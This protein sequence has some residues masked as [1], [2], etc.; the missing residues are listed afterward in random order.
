MQKY[1]QRANWQVC[2]DDSTRTNLVDD[3]FEFYL[4]M[5]CV[6]M[7]KVFN[8]INI[9]MSLWRLLLTLGVQ[10]KCCK[11]TESLQTYCR[12]SPDMVVLI[13]TFAFCLHFFKGWGEVGYLSICSFGRFDTWC[14]LRGWR[15]EALS[16][17]TTSC[18]TS[19]S[20]SPRSQR[21]LCH[22]TFSR[23][24][25]HM[26]HN[27]PASSQGHQDSLVLLAVLFW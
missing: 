22:S 5:G 10:E 6:F 13:P 9:F 21:G 1:D 25:K 3:I 12:F 27:S 19:S 23:Y 17:T 2:E 16:S 11:P 24:S 15:R 8:C 14:W 4:L 7:Q 26:L 20:D 18:R